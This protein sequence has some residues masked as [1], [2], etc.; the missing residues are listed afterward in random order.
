MWRWGRRR[1][2]QEDELAAEIQTHLDIEE[3]EHLG[4]G[5]RPGEARAAARKAFGNVGV[6]QEHVRDAWGWT[7]VEQLAQDVRYAMRTLRRSPGFGLRGGAVA[8]DGDRHER[9]DLQ[10]RRRA[11]VPAAGRPRSPTASSPFVRQVLKRRSAGS[12]TPTSRTSAS[13]I[14]PSHR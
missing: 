3:A 1:E 11:R 14:D 4:R 12:P 13:G 7:M 5:L 10:P 6:V 8:G 2:R 9:G